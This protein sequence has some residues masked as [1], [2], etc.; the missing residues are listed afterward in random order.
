MCHFVS[1]IRFSVINLWALTLE[2]NSTSY[3][4]ASFC[5]FF[6]TN[7][8]DLCLW[9]LLKTFSSVS[10]IPSVFDVNCHSLFHYEYCSS[11]FLKEKNGAYYCT[12]SFL[13]MCVPEICFW[14][15]KTGK[16]LELF[17]MHSR[18]WPGAQILSGCKWTNWCT[19]SLWLQY[20]GQKSCDDYKNVFFFHI[21]VKLWSWGIFV[22]QCYWNFCTWTAEVIWQRLVKFWIFCWNMAR[23]VDFISAWTEVY[24]NCRVVFLFWRHQIFSMIS[25]RDV[26]VFSL[27][28]PV[29]FSYSTIRYPFVNLMNAI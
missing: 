20:N 19:A 10:T 11:C 12:C 5:L 28:V 18:L 4:C 24:R 13:A 21:K 9:L 27:K 16:K 14:P 29:H 3:R 7:S 22:L 26:L 23:F 17:P 25:L 15:A 1:A 2:S 8:G 6:L